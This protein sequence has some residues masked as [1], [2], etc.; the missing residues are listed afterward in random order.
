MNSVSNEGKLVGYQCGVPNRVRE[1]IFE[2][3]CAC[4]VMMMVENETRKEKKG[5]KKERVEDQQNDGHV[6][7][8]SSV[9]CSIELSSSEELT[10]LMVLKLSPASGY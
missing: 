1:K 10:I 4:G 8:P 5:R 3:A 6:R 7:V 2:I 9:P